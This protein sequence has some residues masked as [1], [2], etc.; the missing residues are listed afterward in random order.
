MTALPWVRLSSIVEVYW[1]SSSK[2]PDT[3]LHSRVTFP[4]LIPSHRCGFEGHYVAGGTHSC[5]DVPPNR[6]TSLVR[7]G[8][9]NV[10][11]QRKDSIQRSP[12]LPEMIRSIESHT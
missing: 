5:G 9:K 1:L 12:A 11:F 2:S 8:D 7:Y 6:G 10:T 3:G 4:P